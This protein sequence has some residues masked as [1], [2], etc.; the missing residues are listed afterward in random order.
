MHVVYSSFSESQGKNQCLNGCVA[1]GVSKTLVWLW[2]NNNTC[3][4][5]IFVKLWLKCDPIST[6]FWNKERQGEWW[7]KKSASLELATRGFMH[8][9]LML[10]IYLRAIKFIAVYMLQFICSRWGRPFRNCGK[11]THPHQPHHFLVW[12]C[13]NVPITGVLRDY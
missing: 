13:L 3:M 7:R 8:V 5:A 12:F 4:H 1:L 11:S 6:T 10:H 2:F 9:L